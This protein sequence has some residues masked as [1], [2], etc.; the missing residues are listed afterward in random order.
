MIIRDIQDQ[1]IKSY[2]KGK[3][4][5]IYGARQT[6]KTT[7]VKMLKEKYK[8]K[9]LYLNC[10]EPDVRESLTNK[11]STELRAFIGSHDF[12]IIDEA[13]RVQNIGIT[14]KLI[15]DNIKGVQIIATGSSSFELS[16]KIMEPLTGRKYEFHLYP[17]SINEL[18]QIYP[19]I[20]L[21][22]LLERFMIYGLYPELINTNNPEVL[23]ELSDSYI[24]KDILSYQG[25]KNHDVVIRLLQALALQVGS[26]VS[27]TELSSLLGIDKKTVDNYIN[28]L[29]Q[30][31]IIFRLQP[32]SRNLRNELKK[33]RKIYFFDVGIRNALIKNF[34]TPSLRTDVGALFEN[35]VI[36]EMVK[37]NSNKGERKNIYFWRTH[38]DKEIDYIEES[39]GKLE[40]YEIKFNKEN[41]KFPELFLNTYSGSTISLI[42]KSN[43]FDFF[44]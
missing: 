3:A 9:S 21:K 5:I 6:G 4:I 12:V 16:D 28:I 17:F 41:Y 33:L 11:T 27:Y 13:Q 34:N 39:A 30:A 32:F 40:G 38:Q 37:R 42:N 31:F 19:D 23:S 29:E 18:H 36:A 20:E 25:I 44:G 35:F 7:L 15:I 26:E 2:F 22:R 14:L 10:D 1:I 43:C 24:Y 8:G